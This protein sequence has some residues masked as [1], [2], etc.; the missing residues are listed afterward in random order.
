M[1]CMTKQKLW[2]HIFV[3]TIFCRYNTN[4]IN[5][6]VFQH[7]LKHF[8]ITLVTPG[9]TVLFQQMHQ[10]LLHNPTYIYNAVC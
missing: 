1:K 9:F 5:N 8:N 3:N 4:R 2:M 10:I 6:H 7:E